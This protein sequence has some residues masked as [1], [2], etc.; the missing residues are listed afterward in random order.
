MEKHFNGK[1]AIVTG[2]SRG[3]GRAIA[4]RLAADGA[5]V[6]LCARDSAMLQ[7][8]TK[9][10]EGQGGSAKAI[11]V[12]L[13]T[14]DAAQRVVDFALA[15]YGQIDVLV[16]N[17]G[18]TRRGDFFELTEEDWADGFALKFFGA[19]RLTRAAWP[20]LKASGGSVVN[21][22]GVGGRMPGPYFTIGGSVNAALLSFTKAMAEVGIRDGVQVNAINPGSI[23]TDRFRRMMETSAAQQGI[24]AAEAEKKLIEGN[25]ITRVG[26]PEEIAAL[27][28]FVASQEGRLLQGALI[29]MDGGATKVI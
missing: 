2:S 6:V 28:A 8:A 15:G 16:N 23:R 22:S 1:T 14:D 18:A 11:A 20:H 29:D 7:Q 27:V 12:D 19:V 13:R 17:A 26:E 9:E 3:I 10:I 21:I 25:K 24:H 5:R 4:V